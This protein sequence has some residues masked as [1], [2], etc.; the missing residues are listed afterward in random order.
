MDM[1][2]PLGARHLAGAAIAREAGMLA[3]DGFARLDELDISLKGHQDY[4]TE[5]DLA[6]E[7]LIRARLAA[8][9]PMD[10]ILGEEGGGEPGERVWVL[11]PID[12]TANFARGEPHFAVVIAYVEHGR[13]E[14]G[15]IFDP[16]RDELYSVRRGHGAYRNGRR[17]QASQVGDLRQA[18]IELTYSSR[19]GATAYSA[20]YCRIVEAGCIVRAPGSAALG[21]ARVADGRSDGYYATAHSA[22]DV[23][24][25][26]LLVAEAGGW[27]SDFHAGGDLKQRQPTFAAAP[28]VAVRLQGLIGL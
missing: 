16:M 13:T 22:W 2:D 5:T 8:L 24:A 26:L 11:D 14:L 4:L 12:G 17:I 18:R 23:L 27:A 6:V 10:T 7:H 1:I 9:F 19:L 20:L 3:K 28:G 15:F 21:L 25:G